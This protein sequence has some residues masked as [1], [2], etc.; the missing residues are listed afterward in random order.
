[1]PEI[2]LIHIGLAVLVLII[3]LLLGWVVRA[4]RC[5]REKLAINASWQQQIDSRQSEH[6]RLT[7]QSKGL[8]QQI[9]QYQSS[10]KDSA[11]RTKELSE[12]LQEAVSARVE[13]QDELGKLQ[14]E[15]EALRGELETVTSIRD[16]LQ[17][18]KA[19]QDNEEARAA[20]ALKKKDGKIFRLSQELENWQSRVPPLVERFRAR[21][22]DAKR[23]E[24]ELA[25]ARDEIETLRASIQSDA[26]RIEPAGPDSL[27]A[28]GLDAS[29]EPH[30]QTIA[31]D[32]IAEFRALRDSAADDEQEGPGAESA[33]V[34][35]RADQEAGE[36]DEVQPEGDDGGAMA[37]AAAA[38]AA[39]DDTNDYS[40]SPPRAAGEARDDLQQIKGVGPAIENTLNELGIYRYHQISEM[41]EYDIDRVA[42]KLRG[43]RSRIYRED[44]IGQA[45]ILR[46]RQ[47]GD[48]P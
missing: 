25:A 28:G 40:D 7:E 44:W 16:E 18:Q 47:L 41:S 15:M 17:T 10:H 1:M 34:N 11:M 12:S 3:G 20:E 26:T 23:L 6:D 2:T 22:E 45:R 36:P 37:E 32:D 8:M 5:G 13:M 14:S 27:P 4:D 29:N 48:R 31:G 43:F 33:D 39:D 24:A 19:N 35:P 38:D 21:D 42:R 46:S 30:A 9:S